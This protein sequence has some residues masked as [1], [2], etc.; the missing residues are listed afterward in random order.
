[1]IAWTRSNEIAD[2]AREQRRHGRIFPP[3]CVSRRRRRRRRRPAVRV[4]T[5]ALTHSL[6][7]SLPCSAI[8][9][10]ERRSRGERTPRRPAFLRPDSIFSLASDSERSRV[11]SIGRAACRARLFRRAVFLRHERVRARKGRHCIIRRAAA[12]AR[13]FSLSLPLFLVFC[14]SARSMADDYDGDDYD[15]DDND[16]GDDY[17]STDHRL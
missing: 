15:D 1:M 2:S 14:F 3:A 7:L 9:A 8:R 6:S 4:E 11:R 5:C 17:S 13:R 10:A 16:D 12:R